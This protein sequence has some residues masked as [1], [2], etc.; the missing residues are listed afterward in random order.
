M[1]AD[2]AKSQVRK[3]L[4]KSFVGHKS[5]QKLLNINFISKDFTKLC[6]EF[7]QKIVDERNN[8]KLVPTTS[9]LNFIL[10]PSLI[11]VIILHDID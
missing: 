9:M 8:I 2:G 3:T 1:E 10:N 5:L 11:S 4:N 7:K 6:S